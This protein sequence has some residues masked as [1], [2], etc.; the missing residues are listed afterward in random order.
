MNFDEIFRNF[1]IFN[2]EDQNLLDFQISWDF[3]AEIVEFFR[4]WFSKSK[5]KIKKL[6]LD[7][8]PF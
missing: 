8:N 6:E 5:K 4:K 7:E 2:E 3:E 1:S